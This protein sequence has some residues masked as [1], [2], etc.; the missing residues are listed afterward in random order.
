M[1]SFLQLVAR[2]L[3]DKLGN[4]LSHTVI[5]F[6]NKRASLFMNE[7][8][9]EAATDVPLWAPHYMTINELFRSYLPEVGVSDVVE[10]TL[11]IVILYRQ[12]TQHDVSVDLFYG[13]AER[14]LADFDDVD[15]NMADADALFQNISDWKAF[16][17]LSFLTPEQIQELQRFFNDFDPQ[18][19]S[20]LRE[21]YRRLWDVL[22]SMYHEL[23]RQLSSEGLAYEGA[24]FR[25]VVEG[26]K[27]NELPANPDIHHYAFVGFNVLDKVEQELFVHLRNEGKAW[28]YWDYDVYYTSTLHDVNHE[29]GLFMRENLVRFPNELPPENFNNL[30]QEKHIEMISGTTEAI[31]AQYVLPWLQQHLTREDP[32]RTAVVLC[33]ENLLQPV[34]HTIP[35]D[36]EQ[37]NITKGYPLSHTDAATLVERQFSEWE[38]RLPKDVALIELLRLLVEKVNQC[39]REFVNRDGYDD[40]RF[41]DI[42]QGE[43]YYQ[44]FTLLNR[45]VKIF[46]TLTSDASLAH[47]DLSLVTLRRIV[48]QTIRQTNVPFHGEPAVGLQVMGVLE[49]RCLDFDHILMLSVND[50]ML[51]KKSADNSFIPFLLRKSFGLTTPDRRTAVYAYYFYRLLQRASRV[52][53]C[54]NMSTDGM[55]SGEMSRFMTQLLV[56]W[57]GHVKHYSLNSHQHIDSGYPYAHPKPHD[58]IQRLTRDEHKHPSLSP[59]AIKDYI[60]C[61]LLFF[62]KHILH[63]TEP[64]EEEGADE[65]RP[66]SFGNIFHHAAELVYLEIIEHHGGHVSAEYLKHLAADNAALRRYVEQAFADTEHPYRLLE[67]RVIEMYLANLLL[68]DAAQGDFD[69]IGT[70]RNAHCYVSVPYNTETVTFFIKGIID[71]LDYFP[72]LHQLRVFDYKTGHAISDKNGVAEARAKSVEE[73][74]EA[75]STKGNMLQ[76][77]LYGLMLPQMMKSDETLA[78]YADA[79]ISPALFY[80][81]VASRTTYDPRLTIGSDVVTDLESYMPDF[82]ACLKELIAEIIDTSRDFEP[83]TKVKTCDSC[84]YRTICHVKQQ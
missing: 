44:M 76:T 83:T 62:F 40:S 11:R 66:Q 42:L 21:R 8:L 46:E 53:M 67:G 26:L 49:T 34:L 15:K 20:E 56:E 24:L 63:I 4:D 64:Q 1:V 71:R 23:N 58:I 39:G 79:N 80:I 5:V 59:S 10:T 32:K 69:V 9:L 30:L 3:Y 7:Y 77:F 75:N 25:R 36:I 37:I 55:T 82:E 31:Q 27:R 65:L 12:L 73:L 19:K 78:P 68:F 13:W 84:A 28:F 29:A 45:Y 18:K 22:G 54:Y 52:S 17:D 72:M 2:D 48:R 81:R 14:L 50:G 35:S 70:E 61:Q 33:N 57:P 16:D 74:F 41:E 51:P 47:L 60:K 38:R 6:P 43:G